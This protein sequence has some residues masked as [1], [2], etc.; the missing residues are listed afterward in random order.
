MYVGYRRISDY[1]PTPMAVACVVELL[2]GGLG[3][4]VLTTM[5]PGV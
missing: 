1:G 3:A 2:F 4:H 5:Q